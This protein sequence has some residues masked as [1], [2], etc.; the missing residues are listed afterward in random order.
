M[1]LTAS[2]FEDPLSSGLARRFILSKVTGEKIDEDNRE[3]YPLLESWSNKTFSSIPNDNMIRYNG[4]DF[5]TSGNVEQI[6]S[7][8]T[9]YFQLHR[10]DTI[11]QIL[12]DQ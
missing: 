5:Y 11:D 1:K 8:L 4:H 12:K 3:E 7:Q 6:N 10:D 2:F 9:R